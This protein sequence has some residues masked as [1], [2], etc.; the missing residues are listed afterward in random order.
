[1]NKQVGPTCKMVE[2][3]GVLKDDMDEFVDG[4]STVLEE[5]KAIPRTW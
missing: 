2:S 3:F 1:M 5:V 4:V